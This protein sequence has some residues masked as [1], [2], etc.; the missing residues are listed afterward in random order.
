MIDKLN[1]RLVGVYLVEIKWG[2]VWFKDAIQQTDQSMKYEK[3]I[4]LLLQKFNE[5]Q[6]SKINEMLTT[7]NKL[8]IDFDKSIVKLVKEKEKRF[9]QYF[10]SYFTAKAAEDWLN[11]QEDFEDYMYKGD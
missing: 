5:D 7:N 9:D 2:L 4:N 10:A 11:N 3:F 1:N 8:I 6:I